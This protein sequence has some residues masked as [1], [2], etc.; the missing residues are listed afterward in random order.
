MAVTSETALIDIP[1]DAG[2]PLLGYSLQTMRDPIALAQAR[3]RKYGDVSWLSSFG[4]RFITLLGPDANQFVLQNR[5]DLFANDAWEYFL[6]DFFHRGLML[7][8]FA[9]HKTHRRVMQVAFKRDAMESYLATLQPHIQAG[10]DAWQPGDKFLAFNHFKQLTLDLA[11]RVFVGEPPGADADRVN[12]AFFDTVRAPTSLVRHGVPGGRWRRGQRSRRVLEQFFESRLAAKRA[13]NDRDLFARLATAESEDG[14]RLT[15]SDVVN[16][17]IFLLMAAH[18]TSTITLTN[19]VYH[20]AREPAWQERLREES[21]ALGRGVP[22]RETLGR[23]ETMDRVMHEA[24]RLTTPV[25]GL[26]RRATQDTEFT[27]FHIPAGHFVN[28]IPCHTHRMEQF[29]DAPDTFDPDRFA[30]PREEHKRHP[31]QFMPF[32]G[33]AHK[34][35]GLHFG[36]ME[37][38]AIL[39]RMLLNFRWTVPAGYVMR[40][41]YTSLPVPKDRLPITLQRI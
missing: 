1:G 27:G 30:K 41:D 35:I 34:C 22:N 17:M 14:E 13:G 33:G 32:G 21:R 31:Y 9:E 6:A 28:I 5:G 8:D 3:R 4:Q 2:W 29:W 23:L 25:P 36:E 18:D 38:K 39:H 20:L 10:L 12:R 24:L 7:L 11:A 15:D 16:H 40:Q 37:V 26:P 19:M